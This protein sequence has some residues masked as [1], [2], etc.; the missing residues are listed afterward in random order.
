M[1]SEKERA[2][3]K[4]WNSF[5]YKAY[6]ETSVPDDATFPRI[7]YGV[8][9]DSLGGVVN[10]HADL[11]FRST[12]WQGVTDLAETIAITI[13]QFGHVSLPIEGGGYIYLCGGTPFAQRIDD[14]SDDSI[15]RIYINLQAE[16]LTA[17]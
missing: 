5:G 15:K 2:L 3:H 17:Y 13:K 14:P 9:T 7:T 4:F 6:D 16:F 11:W 10:L 8:A 1:S 12:S